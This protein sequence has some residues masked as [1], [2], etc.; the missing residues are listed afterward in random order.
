MKIIFFGSG[1]FAVK[2]LETLYCQKQDVV[3]VV[4]Q[5]DRK[6]GRH[7]H[8]G[9]TPVKE[10]ALKHGL[11]ILQTENI[12]SEESIA[13]IASKDGDIFIV[14]SFGRILS[15]KLLCC[16]RIMPVNIHASLLPKYRG[17]A[18][19]NRALMNGDKITGVTFIKMNERMDEGDI[20]LRKPLR[21]TD[22]DNAVTLDSRLSDLA[23]KNLPDLLDKISNCS[24]KAI[25]Q[26]NKLATYAPKLKKEDGL[27]C[28]KNSSQKILNYFK[29]CYGWPGSFT[30]YKGKI[31]KIILMKPHNKICRGK[32][33][34]ILETNSD[35]LVVCCGRG[36]VAIQEVLPES[37]KKMS[38]QSFLAGYNVKIGE[39]LGL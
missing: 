16:A 17:A 25:K 1:N 20:I 22:N 36:C 39:I 3:L 37:H 27:I 26:N 6:K 14:V 30:H 34:E 21:I 13:K 33:G 9:S 15:G 11:E 18:P 29:G 5:P 35:C 24:Y 8:L 28:W 19:I 2:I 32:P 4:T 10:Y 38:V 7:L 23:A 12:N 31:L